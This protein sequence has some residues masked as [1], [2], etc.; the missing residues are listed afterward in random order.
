MKH[1]I[2]WICMTLLCIAATGCNKKVKKTSPATE[3]RQ[4]E[5]SLIEQ[6]LLELAQAS[7]EYG[8]EEGDVTDYDYGID[9]DQSTDDDNSS[10]SDYNDNGDSDAGSDEGTASDDSNNDAPE[11]TGW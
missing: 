5:Q 10:D 1:S 8:N 3:S 9:D 11:D 4:T 6:K 2:I 7:D